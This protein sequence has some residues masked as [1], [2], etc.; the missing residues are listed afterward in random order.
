MKLILFNQIIFL[1]IPL[2]TLSALAQQKSVDQKNASRK[3]LV[4]HYVNQKDLDTLGFGF[5]LKPV[6]PTFETA[7]TTLENWTV[8]QIAQF[9]QKMSATD[10]VKKLDMYERLSFAENLVQYSRQGDTEVR[11]AQIAKLSRQLNAGYDELFIGLSGFRVLDYWVMNGDSSVRQLAEQIVIERIP[12]SAWTAGRAAPLLVHNSSEAYYAALK[13]L[14]LN[15]DTIANPDKRSFHMQVYFADALP[16]VGRVGGKE[17]I[18][19]MLKWLQQVVDDKPHNINTFLDDAHNAFRRLLKYNEIDKTTTQSLTEE[20]K[21]F[22]INLDTSPDDTALDIYQ[23]DEIVAKAKSAGLLDSDLSPLQSY[24]IAKTYCMHGYKLSATDILTHLNILFIYNSDPHSGQ[25]HIISGS[26]PYNNLME[27][28][29]TAARSD[30]PDF[31]FDS[32][33]HKDHNMDP[34]YALMLGNGKEAFVIKLTDHNKGDF[35]HEALSQL[36]NVAL[37]YKKVEKRFRYQV[38]EEKQE[39][40]VRYEKRGAIAAFLDGL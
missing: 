37:A 7:D 4:Y 18:P 2:S 33:L 24:E 39:V 16:E 12:G 36:F 26:A 35:H 1:L 19:L 13:Q 17:A 11:L 14:K 3:Q 30:L 5:K 31:S 25:S 27:Q 15:V 40:E 28:F 38:N 29:M 8:E 20:L 6:A 22:G 34:N 9:E 32:Y 21:N 23:L 10:A